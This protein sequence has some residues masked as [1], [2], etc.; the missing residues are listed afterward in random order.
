[1]TDTNRLGNLVSNLVTAA[2]HTMWHA[3]GRHEYKKPYLYHSGGTRL[4]HSPSATT[5]NKYSAK[6]VIDVINIYNGRYNSYVLG[7][8]LRGIAHAHH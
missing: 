1:M 5:H 6:F 7:G 2:W 4:K 8:F 3:E